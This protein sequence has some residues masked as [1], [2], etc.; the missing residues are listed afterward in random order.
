MVTKKSMLTK[1]NLGVNIAKEK[2]EY[3]KLSGRLKA[4][5]DK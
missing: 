3:K 5:L 2:Y 1:G 4:V